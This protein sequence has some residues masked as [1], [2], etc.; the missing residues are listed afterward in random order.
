MKSSFWKALTNTIKKYSQKVA[1]KWTFILLCLLNICRFMP[2]SV[3]W[4]YRGRVLLWLDVC[5]HGRLLLGL[6]STLSSR[7]GHWL[8]ILMVF[9]TFCQLSMNVLIHDYEICWTYR[10]IFSSFSRSIVLVIVLVS[11]CLH[12]DCIE[13][14]DFHLCNNSICSQISFSMKKY[15]MDFNPE[16]V[17]FSDWRDITQLNS[18]FEG[19][20]AWISPV[21]HGACNS[22]HYSLHCS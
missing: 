22:I 4:H 20:G 10:S 2:E 21:I 12:D 18:L 14:I 8:K 11:A 7:G 16:L 1:A 9:N 3:R 13:Y 19:C 6:Y 15:K 5:C 17:I